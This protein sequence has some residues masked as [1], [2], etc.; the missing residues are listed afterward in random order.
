MGLIR[1]SLEALRSA[2]LDG[3]QIDND[4]TDIPGVKLEFRHVRMTRHDALPQRLL[5][6]FDRITLP[7][8]TK[9]RSKLV[10]TFAIA[11]DRMTRCAIFNKQFFATLE[12]LRD[13]GLPKRDDRNCCRR[14]M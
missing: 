3:L 7:E 1:L 6:G 10:R 5:Q 11:A 14:R 8:G 13:R 4:G 9:W 12:A 2:L